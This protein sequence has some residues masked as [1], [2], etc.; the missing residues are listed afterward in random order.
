MLMAEKKLRDFLSFLLLT[1]L[2]TAAPALAAPAPAGAAEAGSASATQSPAALT[3][4]ITGKSNK[5]KTISIEVKGK[6]EFVKF[7]DKTSGLEHAANGEAAIVVFE[8]RGDERYATVVKPKLAAL[9]EGVTEMKPDELIKL[10][11]MGP[12][13][14]KYLL[15]DSRPAPRYHEGHIPTA[16]SIPETALKEKGEAALPAEAKSKDLTLIFYCGGYT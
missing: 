5:A 2:L 11:A 3:G 16:I 10:V 13:A 8:M 14:G 4:K 1:G 7:D 9:P 15:I 12:E 6:N